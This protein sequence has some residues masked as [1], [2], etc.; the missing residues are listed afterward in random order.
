M[1]NSK[2]PPQADRFSLGR[3]TFFTILLFVFSV[4]I[5]NAQWQ[6]EV[7]LTNDPALTYNC[8]T[9]ARSIAASGNYVHTIF[10]DDREGNFEVYYKRSIDRGA[11]F[12]TDQRL[13]FDALNSHNSAIAVSGSNVYIVW[14]D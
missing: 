12:E 4:Q 8:Y 10:T 5:S 11:S 3:V 6:S 2:I 7:R 9:G 1:F 14:Y 13:T